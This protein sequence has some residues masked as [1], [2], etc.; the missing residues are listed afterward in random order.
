MDL[1]TFKCVYEDLI[2][3]DRFSYFPSFFSTFQ[4]T[5]VSSENETVEESTNSFKVA[6]IQ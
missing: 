6:A 3:F 1:E 4:F 2:I 5:F